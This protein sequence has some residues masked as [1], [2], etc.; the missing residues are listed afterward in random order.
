[1]KQI[2][3][4]KWNYIKKCLAT[5]TGYYLG[6][7]F[8]VYPPEEQN[9]RDICRVLKGC[10]EAADK[11]SETCGLNLLA[12]ED[13]IVTCHGGLS[14]F[15]MTV[16]VN[17]SGELVRIVGGKILARMVD[18]EECIRLAE[19]YGLEPYRVIQAMGDVRIDSLENLVATKALLEAV[20]ESL[21]RE[22]RELEEEGVEDVTLV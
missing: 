6:D 21:F 18:R 5:V 8:G 7:I 11:C 14:F 13:G 22:Q 2:S 9:E 10:S 4:E 19:K 20:L 1:M 12:R 3:I 17:G 16:P 15:A